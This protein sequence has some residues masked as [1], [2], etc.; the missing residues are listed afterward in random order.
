MQ[1]RSKD[2]PELEVN[3]DFDEA[4]KY[5]NANKKKQANGCYKYICGVEL[6]DGNFCKK[7][8][9]KNCQFCFIH[10]K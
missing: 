6:K 8:Q 5:W 4:S 1:T 2:K 9:Y 3:I 10:K 7:T